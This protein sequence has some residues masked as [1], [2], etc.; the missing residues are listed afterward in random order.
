MTS[1]ESTRY[2]SMSPGIKPYMVGGRIHY[3]TEEEAEYPT[4]LCK[5]YAKGAARSI[6]LEAHVDEVHKMA[7][8]QAIEKDLARYHRC[9]DQELRQKMVKEIVAMEDRCLPGQE[10]V[11]LEWLLAN[12]HY[13]GTGIRLAVEHCGGKHL[14][15]YPA[16]RWEVLSFKWKKD[17][18]IN[19]LEAQALMAHIRKILRDPTMRSTRILVVID[20]QVLYYALGNGRSPSTQLNR[21]LRRLMALLLAADV[22]LFPVWTISPWN[23]ADKPSRRA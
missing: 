2:V 20:S 3:P 22:S 8:E 23:W 18:H 1:Y 14:V 15:P 19:I 10:Q 9:D 7:P 12:G 17:E 11:H 13:R 21:V 6:Q 16:H 5:K 4:E